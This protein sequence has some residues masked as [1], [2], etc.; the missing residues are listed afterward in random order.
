M[1]WK[2]R[3]ILLSLIL[4]FVPVLNLR[5]SEPVNRETPIWQDAPQNDA[6]SELDRVSRAYVRLAKD[7]RPSI[8]QIRVVP[9]LDTKAAKNQIGQTSTEKT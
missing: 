1:D 5:A 3:P 8:V 9:Q 6:E 2:L 4:S 7:A